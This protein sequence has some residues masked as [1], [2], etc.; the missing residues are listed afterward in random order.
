MKQVIIKTKDA[1]IASGDRQSITDDVYTYYM[2]SLIVIEG[3]EA[4]NLVE[5]IVKKIIKHAFPKKLRKAEGKIKLQ[6]A[7]VSIVTL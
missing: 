1:E 4:I 3:S 2:T 5:A 6:S 7:L